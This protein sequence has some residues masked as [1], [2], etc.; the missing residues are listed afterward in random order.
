MTKRQRKRKATI[1]LIGRDPKDLLRLFHALEEVFQAKDIEIRVEGAERPDATHAIAEEEL[2]TWIKEEVGRALDERNQ[3]HRQRER[4]EPEPQEKA[5]A[6]EVQPGTSK[7]MTKW[8][9]KREDSERWVADLLAAGWRI[10][11]KV[12]EKVL[13]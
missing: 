2:E 5:P 12:I 3:Q 6:I 8:L 1:R 11:V 13:K 4:A 7:P 10:L 9:K